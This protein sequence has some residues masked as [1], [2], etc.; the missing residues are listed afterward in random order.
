M[1]ETETSQFHIYNLTVSETV[2]L[3]WIC[4]EE[5]KF[6][7]GL[8]MN[9]V[10]PKAISTCYC[11][12]NIPGGGHL[13]N[14]SEEIFSRSND[15]KT[16]ELPLHLLVQPAV[17]WGII[18]RHWNWWD[19]G[20]RSFYLPHLMK[21]QNVQTDV[22]TIAAPLYN[23]GKQKQPVVGFAGEHCHPSF[24]R[25]DPWIGRMFCWKCG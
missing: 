2:L 22:E 19:P 20:T 23:R 10:N 14:D 16:K 6:M 13:H 25:L 5:S 9:Q 3:A 17:H 15:S 11:Y 8:K 7:E 24:Y 1:W 4:G 12:H 18:H 21:R